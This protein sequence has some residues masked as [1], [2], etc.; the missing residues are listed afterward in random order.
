MRHFYI[1][2]RGI[3]DRVLALVGLIVLSPLFA[4]VSLCIHFSMGRPILFRQTRIGLNGRRFEILKFRTM[5]PNAM[6]LGG[7]YMPP[8]LNLITPLGGFLRKTSLDEL[9]QLVNVL[10]GDIGIIGPRPALPDQFER[11]TNEQSQRV[12]VPQGITG[13]A[14]VR[15]RNDAPWSVRIATDL[16]YIAQIGPLIDLKILGLT[17]A[18]V[19]QGFGIRTNQIPAD[20]D[21]LGPS[22]P[23]RGSE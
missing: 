4:V 18:R 15:Y 6:E 22:N 3:L 19:F 10:K 7:G 16:E 20:V 11:Y 12:T 2:I 13:L 5:V 8:E 23:K 17:V 14:Q 1:F 9:P 21:D